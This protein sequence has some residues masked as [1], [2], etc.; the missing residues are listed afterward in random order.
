MSTEQQELSWQRRFEDIRT[1][2]EQSAKRERALIHAAKMLH[3]RAG[4]ADD[5]F[6]DFIAVALKTAVALKMARDA[7]EAIA[8]SKAA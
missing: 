4:L 1:E 5:D 2:L 6:E 8:Q 7:A 3:R